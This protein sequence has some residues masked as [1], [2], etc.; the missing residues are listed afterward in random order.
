MSG[1]QRRLT[2]HRDQRT[3]FLSRNHANPYEQ[4]SDD[5]YGKD[6][7]V[8]GREGAF[9]SREIVGARTTRGE[10]KVS[11]SRRRRMEPDCAA[12][13][14]TSELYK[15]AVCRSSPSNAFERKPSPAEKDVSVTPED[16]GWCGSDACP[17]GCNG[18]L[19]I[20]APMRISEIASSSGTPDSGFRH[21]RWGGRALT[22]LVDAV[23]PQLRPD[24]VSRV[25]PR[26]M[27]WSVLVVSSGSRPRGIWTIPP[28]GLSLN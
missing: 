23:D 18:V 14:A 20:L 26:E 7:A 25:N 28:E 11:R 16:L 10:G 19:E 6:S 17:D 24:A 5:R 22:G 2:E 13:F 3:G 4:Q 21:G 8:F 27:I 15:R 12:H 1:V 9:V